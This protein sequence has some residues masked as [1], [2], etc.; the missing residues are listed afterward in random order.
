[1]NNEIEVQ[2]SNEKSYVMLF[3]KN[4]IGDGEPELGNILIKSFIYSLL[5][6]ESKPS[7]MI[8]LNSGAKL[9]SKDSTVLDDLK[10]LEKDKQKEKTED[11][12]GQLDDIF[13]DLM[14]GNATV[15]I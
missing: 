7:T 14:E 1:M 11:L 5:S 10:E 8:F 12:D 15:M 6:L 3:G 2:K 4:F 9:T 13:K